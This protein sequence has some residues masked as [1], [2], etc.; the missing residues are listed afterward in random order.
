[1]S[2]SIRWLIPLCLASFLWAFGFGVSAPL[3]SLWLQDAGIGDSLIGLNTGIYFLGIVL[4]ASLVPRF[5]ERWGYGCL[6]VGMIV[7][8]VTIGLFPWG[9]SL[10]GWFGL[11]SLTGVGS[12][13]S[14]VSLETFIN[15][16]S[17]PERRALNFGCY[18]FS[19]ALGM[20]LGTLVGMAIYPWSPRNAFAIGAVTPLLA[21]AVILGWRPAFPSSTQDRRRPA[22][23]SVVRNFLSFG[24]TWSQGFMEGCMV[25]LLPLYL[26][27]VGL[28]ETTASYLMS[29]LMIGV[30]LAQVPVA[31]LADRFGRAG[32]L[33]ACNV[34]TLVGL[35]GL[36]FSFGTMWLAICLFVAGACSGA[37]YPLGL[38]LLGDRI[39]AS[40]LAR[41][42]GC[43]LSINSLGSL[44]GPI[45]AGHAM[46]RFG[47]P[48]LFVVG[49]VAVGLVFATW[50]ALEAKF[51]LWPPMT[52]DN[53]SPLGEEEAGRVAA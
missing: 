15:R 43:Y 41:A 50:L 48:S 16:R 13:L 12:A 52:A 8:A 31:W 44:V 2:S 46:D 14:L 53:P 23:Y 49:V 32:I 42:N 20:A 24:S 45:L 38:A 40:A 25:G 22:T 33:A 37:F 29:G 17:A 27:Y 30:I 34:L 39:P 6:L 4:A 7:S 36:L 3:A 5:L 28:S 10:A 51:R 9:A 19:I 1:M 47:R 11:R 18:A 21:A 35:V 26:L